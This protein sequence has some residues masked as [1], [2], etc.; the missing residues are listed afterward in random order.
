MLRK[1]LVCTT[2]SCLLSG[3]AS[4]GVK[5]VSGDHLAPAPRMVERPLSSVRE[6]VL[7]AQVPALVAR[8][9]A[10]RAARASGVS[11]RPAKGLTTGGAIGGEITVSHEPPPGTWITVIVLALDRYG[12][13]AGDD[14]W[15][16]DW[17][18]TYDIY[19]LPPGDY[20]VFTLTEGWDYDP[21]KGTAIN[22]FYDNTTDWA[23]A[24]LVTVTEGETTYG[25]DFGLQSNFGS[26]SVTVQDEQGQPLTYAVAGF[27][28]Y[29]CPPAE[30][31]LLDSQ[32]MIQYG[33]M[34]DST[35]TVAVAPVPLGTFY[36]SCNAPNYGTKYYPDTS[37]PAEA[38][39]LELTAV[40]QTI[41]NVTF[42]LPAGGSISGVVV[43]DTLTS[44]QPALG[45]YVRVF[46]PGGDSLVATGMVM[47][48]YGGAY[49]VTG[50]SPGTYV[51]QADPH[52]V[53]P[54]YGA[55]YWNNKPDAQ[56]AN[57]VV[58]QRG[59]TA[60]GIDFNLDIEPRG[61]ISGTL[62]TPYPEAYED[63]Y[64]LLTAL[65]SDDST[66][67]T[68]LALSTGAGEYF[69]YGLDPGNYK[70]AL[71]GFP[72]P[73]IPI[74]YDDASSFDEARVVTVTG[75]DWTMGVDFSLPSAGT[76]SGGVTLAGGGPPVTDV[77]MAVI[78]YPEVLPEALDFTSWFLSGAMVDT[79]GAYV[80]PGLQPG[81]Y[82]VWVATSVVLGSEYG[83]QSYCPEYYGGAFNFYDAALVPVTAGQSTIGMDIE[84][85]PEAVIQGHVY[86]PDGAAASDED[87]EVAVFAY[88]A[89]AGYPVG[90]S[91]SDECPVYTENNNTFSAAYRIRTLP[92]GAVKV[93][94]VPYGAQ[95][96]VG[97]YGGGN[98]FDQGGTVQLTAGQTYPSDVEIHL[99]QGTE[100]ISGTVT[101]ETTGEPFDG[102]YV[103]SYDPTGHLTGV[104][105]S[106]IDPATGEAW[107]SGKYQITSLASGSTHYVRTSSLHG[108]F[109]N[110]FGHFASLLG[111]DPD[112]EFGLDFELDFGLDFEF[113]FEVEDSLGDE[114]YQEVP[115]RFAPVETGLYVP[116]LSVFSFGVAPCAEVPGEA[117]PVTA[118]SS[119]IDLTLG[120][121]IGALGRTTC[122]HPA[123]LD[124]NRSWP[125]PSRD[126]VS[127][128]FTL[129]SAQEVRVE[130][131]DVVGRRLDSIELGSLGP[132]RNVAFLGFDA[133]APVPA[134]GVYVLRVVG[135][136]ANSS[137]SIVISR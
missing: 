125:N 92:A 15:Y 108:R 110:A 100:T 117:T 97:Y 48:F 17:G 115:A 116:L 120:T 53:Y 50:L 6:K 126:G 66:T 14:Y 99:S 88:D 47:D 38:Q 41:D 134:P 77:A 26:L 137:A 3:S 2:V 80:L 70:V 83:V 95:A 71:L 21:H 68:S 67:I 24:T 122:P 63:A 46:E 118:P 35:G 36:M 64:F 109:R 113:G 8:I 73:L 128:E 74:Y 124:L 55:K 106:G 56:S 96:T 29:P 85:D 105:T 131:L 119:G 10:D 40:G 44:G 54:D 62:S 1:V 51:V 19:D 121:V 9:P 136:E 4:A 20:Y 57:P 7:A 49:T 23:Q 132:G 94:A 5:I 103:A 43:L 16:S 33:F 104:A 25:V 28:L 123:A 112:F 39:S 45:A 65:P 76:I 69:I 93:A 135:S 34:T 82:R 84:L 22:E 87:V 37:D 79:L 32:R 111:L 59:Q 13:V 130:L 52:F 42:G 86:L 89:A 75:W 129:P 127:L 107:V 90:I 98:T 60:M 101:N 31:D 72:Y 91:F 61:G 81:F 114:W 18:G 30:F 11:L 78:A 12:Y 102:V 58:V 27:D 133:V